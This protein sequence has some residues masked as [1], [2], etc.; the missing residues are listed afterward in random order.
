MT[1]NHRRIVSESIFVNVKVSAA[2]STVAHLD[3]NLIVATARFFSLSQFDVTD[4][5]LIFDQSFDYLY[6]QISI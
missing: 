5:R 2:N 6:L 4:S 1:E 3:L